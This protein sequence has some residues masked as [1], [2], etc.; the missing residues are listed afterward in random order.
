MQPLL[1]PD[2]VESILKATGKPILDARNGVIVSRID[3]LA[4]VQSVQRAK[5]RRR[6]AS[7]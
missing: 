6:A 2:E 5:P 1:T 3:L 4:A 7:H